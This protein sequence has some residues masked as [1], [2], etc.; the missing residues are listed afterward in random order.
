MKRGGVP[1]KILLVGVS[2]NGTV[3]EGYGIDLGSPWER[4]EYFSM[5]RENVII[6]PSRR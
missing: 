6:S 5:G 2:W 4:F 3:S 1:G